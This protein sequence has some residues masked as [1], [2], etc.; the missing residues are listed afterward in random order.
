MANHVPW[1]K[2]ISLPYFRCGWILLSLLLFPSLLFQ[3][4]GI[5]GVYLPLCST[6]LALPACIASPAALGIKPLKRGDVFVIIAGY[7]AIIVLSALGQALWE[8]LLKHYSIP[9]A[10]QQD[11]FELLLQCNRLQLL[12][13]F[14]SV[15][16]LTPVVEEILF[17][18]IIYGEISKFNPVLAFIL[19]SLL[20]SVVHFFIL[21]IPGLFIMGIFF[22]LVCLTRQNLVLSMLLHGL[23]NSIALGV[24]LLK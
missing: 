21:G 7:I 11:L 9:Y 3:F 4:F 8:R 12:L 6:L 24:A 23:V 20:F 2:E 5:S 13:I 22:Q 17:R 15:C 1:S 18:R 14:I 16:L 10:K 19:T